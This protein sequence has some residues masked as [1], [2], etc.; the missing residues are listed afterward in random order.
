MLL[1]APAFTV[2][3]NLVVFLLLSSTFILQPG[4]AV[5][6][7][8]SPFLLSP[9]RDPRIVS[10]TGPPLSAIFFQGEQMNLRRLRAELQKLRGRSQTIVIKADGRALYE[11]ISTVTNVALEL[12]FPVVLATSEEAD[13]R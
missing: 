9:E 1:L 12:G 10:I 5:Q 6:V 8:T 11:K 7:P 4:I 2:A 13:T 3:L